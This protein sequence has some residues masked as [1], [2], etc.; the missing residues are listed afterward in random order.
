MYLLATVS[1]LL[2]HLCSL[3]APPTALSPYLTKLD[4][5]CSHL[6][7]IMILQT[8]GLRQLLEAL[9][10]PAQMGVPPSYW[11]AWQVGQLISDNRLSLAF[12]QVSYELDTP[13]CP[14]PSLFNAMLHC[15]M[16]PNPDPSLLIHMFAQEDGYLATLLLSSIIAQHSLEDGQTVICSILSLLS[17][18]PSPELLSKVVL[19]VMR[20]ASLEQ[21]PKCRQSVEQW[22][23]N[24]MAALKDLL[25]AYMQ[26]AAEHGG[27]ETLTNLIGCFQI[28]IKTALSYLSSSIKQLIAALAS[29]LIHT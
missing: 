27:Q 21:L 4:A 2:P 10:D 24:K 7:R 19:S 6:F 29:Q 11:W 18:W 3:A 16:S 9:T 5:C 23:N 8:C 26:V 12:Y 22:L 14:R 1:S 25:R 28:D 13:L 17:H 20:Q 15:I